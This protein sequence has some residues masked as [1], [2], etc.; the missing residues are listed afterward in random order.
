MSELLQRLMRVR[1]EL[2][3]I[4]RALTETRS[5]TKAQQ[6]CLHDMLESV[7]MLEALL[8]A[9]RVVLK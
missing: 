4:D 2:A 7:N 9:A 1:E 8:G 3:A 6:R 5:A